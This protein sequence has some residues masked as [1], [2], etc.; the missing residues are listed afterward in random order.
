[1]RIL[2]RCIVV[3]GLWLL[4]AISS[5]AQQ[6]PGIQPAA[7][8][9][10]ARNSG[11]IFSG[12]VIAVQRPAPRENAVAYT[13]ISFRVDKAIQGVGSG[14][15]FTIREW[16]GLWDSGERYRSGE[17]VLLF[18]YPTSKLGFTS[19]VAGP[20]GRF[21]VDHVG[22]IHINDPQHIFFSF[23]R[24]HLQFAGRTRVSSREFTHAILHASEN[25]HEQIR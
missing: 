9:Q 17:R 4:L 22:N 11:Y 18:L 3:I 15:I 19:P 20:L 6:K 2:R 7:L 1:M 13:R 21:A 10:L 12:T 25:E 23:N 14:E 16:S 8:D 24:A 5:L